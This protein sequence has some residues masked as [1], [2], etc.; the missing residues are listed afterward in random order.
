MG[1]PTKGWWM[2]R[3]VWGIAG[4]LIA[5][6]ALIVG[7]QLQE[8]RLNAQQP[9]EGQATPA[10]P[11][12]G[13][14]TIAYT[15]SDEAQMQEFG[16]LWRQHQEVRIRMAVLQGYLTQ[17]QAALA[18][19]NQQFLSKYNLDVTKNYSLDTDRK[20]ILERPASATPEPGAQPALQPA[21]PSATP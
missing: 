11:T 16:Q 3:S 19:L 9:N 8:K 1:E 21:A 6:V 7:L 20:V 18:Q 14:E 2:K 15:F 5:V 10:A 4:I 17:E 13:E 12:S